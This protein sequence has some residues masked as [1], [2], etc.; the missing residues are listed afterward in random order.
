MENNNLKIK[1]RNKNKMQTWFHETFTPV[2]INA[3][4]N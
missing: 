3:L 1:N 4:Q 2:L